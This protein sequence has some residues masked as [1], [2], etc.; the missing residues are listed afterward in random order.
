M[1]VKF[2]VSVIFPMFMSSF[3]IISM[4]FVLFEIQ[5]CF[6][7]NSLPYAAVY[8][9]HRLYVCKSPPAIKY[10]MYKDFMKKK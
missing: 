3:N 5:T 7:K 4:H 1:N 2:Y 6:K 9:E 10:F 8:V